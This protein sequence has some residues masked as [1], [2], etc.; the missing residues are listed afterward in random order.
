MH[1]GIVKSHKTNNFQTTSQKGRRQGVQILRNEAYL[2]YTAMTKDEAQC[3][4]RPFCEAV[5]A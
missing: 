4:I 1:N 5:N 3:S 2:A